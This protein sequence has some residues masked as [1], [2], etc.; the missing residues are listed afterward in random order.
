MT[1]SLTGAAVLARVEKG[2]ESSRRGG[3]VVMVFRPHL[4]TGVRDSEV[5][6][7]EDVRL[8]FVG[9]GG[10]DEVVGYDRVFVQDEVV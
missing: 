2:E 3:G 10:E 1:M 9:F 4:E 7:F 5:I 8:W 6:F